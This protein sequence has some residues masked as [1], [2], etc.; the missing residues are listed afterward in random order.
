MYKLKVLT[1][2]QCV[3]ESQADWSPLLCC[4][5]FPPQKKNS[6]AAVGVCAAA[7]VPPACWSVLLQPEGELA[8]ELQMS[9]MENIVDI[10][11]ILSNIHVVGG[12]W[13]NGCLTI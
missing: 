11:V 8:A 4:W 3:C 2:L 10:F 6:A 1:N 12:R 5:Y 9:L 7:V 13:S